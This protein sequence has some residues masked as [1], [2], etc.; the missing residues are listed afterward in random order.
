[1]KLQYIEPIT[2]TFIDLDITKSREEAVHQLA[3]AWCT[4]RG[5]PRGQSSLSFFRQ[6][7]DMDKTVAKLVHGLQTDKNYAEVLAIF[8]KLHSVAHPDWHGALVK[9]LVQKSGDFHD[10]VAKDLIQ[11]TKLVG[12]IIAEGVGSQLSLMV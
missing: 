11:D 3:T 7:E 12:R 6:K 1:M 10:P 4:Q 9:G 8:R 2:K 5:K